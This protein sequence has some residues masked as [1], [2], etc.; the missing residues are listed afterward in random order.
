MAGAGAAISLSKADYL[1][2][3]LSDATDEKK[4]RKKKKPKSAAI[5]PR[6]RIVDD[7]IDFKTT[8][9]GNLE[10]TLDEDVGDDDPTVAEIIDERPDHVKR[11]ESYR[12][13]E[14]KWRLMNRTENE[15]KTEQSLQRRS[16]H[17]SDSDQSPL[18]THKRNDSNSDQSPPR[19]KKR[20]DSDSDQSPPR[21]KKRN[22]SDSDQSPPRR[23]K[24]NDSD[25]DQSPP[26][27]KKRNDSD[28]D[29]SPP[30]RK[31]RNDSDSDQ[32]PPRRKKRNGSD[33][34]Q[35]PPRR[36]KRNGSDS[37]QSPPRR[38]KRNDSDSDQS[39]PRRKKRNDSDSD[40][41]PPRRNCSSKGDNVGIQKQNSDDKMKRTLS[42]KVA[43]LSSAADMKKES[44]KMKAKEEA[45]FKKIGTEL[46]GKDAAT[47]FRD[48]KSGRRRNL[49]QEE[50]ETAEERALKAVKDAKYQ[51]WGKGLKQK[52]VKE[53]MMM[54]Q[55]HEI[56]KPLA[57][58][59]DD[60]DLDSMLREQDREGDPMLA[61]IK[62]KKQKGGAKVKELPRYKG[63]AG[64][65]NRYG[66]QP[67][68]RWDGVNRSNG[69][70]AQLFAKM[71]DRKAVANQAYKWSVEDM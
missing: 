52:E 41:S 64:P 43:G 13:S 6:S 3:Y 57:R 4:K 69:F 5:A 40:Q 51:D 58:Y 44:V 35:S 14:G 46:L 15:S 53:S 56:S 32:S 70:E 60:A 9:P 16:R 38:K 19:R 37:D 63:P 29:Q 30:R 65:P 61:F 33:S 8:L 22:D 67:G 27:R 17:D 7:D 28:S 36:K 31:K 59:R 66:I 20:N 47:V 49:A 45:A 1:K 62:K 71:S 42:G 55:L 68:Y 21:R 18:R 2:R 50:E 54:D 12:D 34:D 26:R 48:K 11:L 25:S 24:R 23:K 10:N 39:P